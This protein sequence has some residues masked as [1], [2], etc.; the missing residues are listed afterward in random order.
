MHRTECAGALSPDFLSVHI[1]ADKID[2]RLLEKRNPDVLAVGAGGRTG[3]A[4][5]LMLVFQLGLGDLLFPQKRAVP[6][7]ET[8]QNALALIFQ[9]GG[10]V[11]P[12]A[13][14]DRG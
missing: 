8:K 11:N 4:V 6:A 2:L 12:L 13:K 1:E 14:D 5:Q 3:K 9:A 7:R 10:E